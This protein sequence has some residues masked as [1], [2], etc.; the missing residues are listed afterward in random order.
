MKNHYFQ[1]IYIPISLATSKFA[2]IITLAANEKYCKALAYI[3]ELM[4]SA[5]DI[6]LKKQL[7][8]IALQLLSMKGYDNIAT[9]LLEAMQNNFHTNKAERL[10]KETLEVLTDKTRQA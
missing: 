7:A 2:K 4:I 9:V 3:D 1:D 5:S 10:C 6:E 8:L